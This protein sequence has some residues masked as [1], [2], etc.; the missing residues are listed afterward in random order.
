MATTVIRSVLAR[1]RATGTGGVSV[2]GASIPRASPA[3][4]QRG[5]ATPWLTRLRRAHWTVV[6][7]VGFAL[8]MDYLIYGLAIPL[9]PF[10]FAG[11]GSA[12][13]GALLSLAYAAGV[14]LSTPVFGYLGD[15]VGCRSPMICGVA[16]A[17]AAT[18]LAGIAPNLWVMLLARLAQGGAAAATWTAGLALVAMAYA[19]KRVQMMGVAT[20]GSTAGLVVGPL[21]GGWL[22]KAGGYALP[23]MVAGGLLAVDALLRVFLLPRGSVEAGKG[24][25]LGDILLSRSIAIPALAVALAAAAWGVVEPL[26]PAH[27]LKAASAGAGS[28]GLLFTIAAAVSGLSAPLVGSVAER[29]GVKTT[30]CLGTVAT[31]AALPLLTAFSGVA[32]VGIA[33]AL[34]SLSFSFLIN[35]ASAELGNAVERRGMHCYAAAYAVY[36]IAYSVGMM[37]A[38]AFAAAMSPRVGVARIFLCTSG[39]LLVCLPLVLLADRDPNQSTVEGRNP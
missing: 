14:L 39:A 19:A 31:A 15:R 10:A 27:L 20:A 1:L 36:N 18:L 24:T 12:E 2:R 38:G 5:M 4:A 30:M 17:G 16:L 9:A 35:P 29:A 32:L 28:V 13:Q 33:L 8:F 7:V 34:V 37:G 25:R 26:L 22:H 21:I 11:A 6:G 23:F 3:G